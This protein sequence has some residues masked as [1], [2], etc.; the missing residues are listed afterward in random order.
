MSR[1]GASLRL[2]VNEGLRRSL[3]L[4]LDNTNDWRIDIA[5]GR[6]KHRATH[7]DSAVLVK[8]V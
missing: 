1:S 3:L 5:V 2:W 4:Q 7:G 8:R 6:P